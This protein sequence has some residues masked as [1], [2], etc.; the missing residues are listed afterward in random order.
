LSK[1]ADLN[2]D[3]NKTLLKLIDSQN[4]C[5]YLH[6]ES[7][8]KELPDPLALPDL[9]LEQRAKLIYTRIFPY[10]KIPDT[11]TDAG[12]YLSVYMD[13][14]KKG[15]SSHW[16]DSRLVFNII[17][18]NSQLRL[19]G[20]LRTYGI[21]HEIDELFNN[22]RLFGIGK[23]QFYRGLVLRVNDSFSGYTIEYNIVDF[24]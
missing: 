16:K 2:E 20:K 22:Q 1:F 11:K 7:N 10:P 8:E 5:K 12:S 14:I 21:L 15:D 6:Y 4:L 23:M 9:T 3:I 19:D 17:C 24:S 18:H 13:Y